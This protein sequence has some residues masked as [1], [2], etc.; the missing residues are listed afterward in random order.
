VHHQRYKDN[1]SD[2]VAAAKVSALAVAA[3][4][5]DESPA[6]SSSRSRP[7]GN[8]AKKPVAEKKEEPNQKLGVLT[9]LL[10]LGAL[11]PS[12]TILTKFPWMSAAYSEV[13]DL[14]LRIV[15]ISLQPLYETTSRP[16]AAL[17]RSNTTPRP[18]YGANGLVPP[19][20]RKRVLTLWAPLP[21]DTASSEFVFF[22]PPWDSCIPRCTEHSDIRDVLVPLLQYVGVQVA[23]DFAFVTKICRI[24]KVQLTAGVCDI[25]HCLALHQAYQSHFRP[26]RPSRTRSNPYG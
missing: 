16:N 11:R 15:R 3:P 18:R 1:I 7:A 21:P 6:N 24:G 12:I 9:A 4:L 10:S 23:R 8:D 17:I 22:Y 20:T 26:N 25:A 5:T 13:A 19:P 14:F 2:R